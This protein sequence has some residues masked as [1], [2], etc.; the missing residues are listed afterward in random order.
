MNRIL[1]MLFNFLSEPDLF[2]LLE[3][4]P[5]NL[6]FPFWKGLQLFSTFFFFLNPFKSVSRLYVFTKYGSIW[7]TLFDPGIFH[8]SVFLRVNWP[9][10]SLP[11][12]FSRP[13]EC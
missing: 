8:S 2:T 13:I 5:L 6:R 12:K 3:S 9:S 4:F 11:E 1:D 10:F 7:S